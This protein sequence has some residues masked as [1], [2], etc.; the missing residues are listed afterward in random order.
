MIRE[1]CFNSNISSNF[2]AIL[3]LKNDQ[4]KKLFTFHFSLFTPIFF[5]ILFPLLWA[6][7]FSHPSNVI[8]GNMN[9]NNPFNYLALGDSYSIGES[10]LLADNFPSQLIAILNEEAPF[11]QPAR[12]VAKTGWTTEELQEGIAAAQK[13]ELLLSRY[14][15]VTLLIGVNDQY[16]GRTVE[17]Y[18]P[19]FEALLQQAIQFAGNKAEQVLVISI[20]DWGV[21]PYANGRDIEQI[22]REIDA[23]NAANK[24]IA[25][26]YQVPYLNITSWTREAATDATLLAA[27]GLHPSGKEYKRWAEKIAEMIKK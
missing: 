25:L 7:P 9:T 1:K 19:K 2:Q 17:E 5:L 21:T 20:P 16:R 4:H 8:P 23:F 3:E 6:T 14:D 15:F 22:G 26:Q 10:I 27:D 18:K 13:N 12:I 11:W 24:K